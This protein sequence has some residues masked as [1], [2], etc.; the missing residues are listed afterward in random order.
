[1]NKLRWLTII[2]FFAIIIINCFS[3]VQPKEK[4]W[5]D[6]PYRLIQT[7]LREIDAIDFDIDVYVESLIDIGANA[8]LI[9][10]GGIVANYYTDLEYQYKNPN[11]KINLIEEV[12]E[13]LHKEGIRVIGRFDFSK[14][15]EKY[16]IAKPDWQYKSVKGEM[17]NYNGQVH[18]CVNGHYQQE[19]ALKILKEALD[20][21]PLDG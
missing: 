8:V 17:V 2:S 4:W 16:A 15:N 14:L 5:M 12:V 6:E 13:R 18:M 10:V 7:N 19:Y 9:N 3:Q 20:K 11:L 1:M 21:F